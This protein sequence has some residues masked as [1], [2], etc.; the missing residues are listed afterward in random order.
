MI[1]RGLARAQTTSTK[2][3]AK[4]GLHTTHPQKLL[5][6]FRGYLKK[7]IYKDL[8]QLSFQTYQTKTFLARSET[9]NLTFYLFLYFCLVQNTIKCI[10]FKEEGRLGLS[11]SS[12]SPPTLS[13]P[14]NAPWNRPWKMIHPR[15][16]ETWSLRSIK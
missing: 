11:W 12:S 10:E 6:H 2:S 9:A 16:M 7:K 8:D 4:L 5:D 1:L 14:W 15:S 3:W 13:T